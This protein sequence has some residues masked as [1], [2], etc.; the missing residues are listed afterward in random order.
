MHYTA[1]IEQVVCW[2]K[3]GAIIGLVEDSD[4]NEI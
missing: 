2:E 1:D 4:F 3:M